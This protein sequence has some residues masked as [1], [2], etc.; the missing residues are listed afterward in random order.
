[1]KWGLN[2][3]G[4]ICQ[5][6]EQLDPFLLDGEPI[7]LVTEYKYLGFWHDHNG[8]AWTRSAR[9]FIEKASNVLGLLR[10]HCSH[11]GP[12]C[13]TELVKSYVRG[14]AEYGIALSVTWE[15]KERRKRR[16]IPAGL[17]PPEVKTAYEE[18]YKDS[19]KWIFGHHSPWMVNLR[20]AGMETPQIRLEILR[21]SV[22]RHLENTEESNPV[23]Q[24]LPSG[25]RTSR[26]MD[27]VNNCFR[28]S[29]MKRPY[30]EFCASFPVTPHWKTFCEYYVYTKML[31]KPGTLHRYVHGL[32]QKWKQDMVLTNRNVI[33]RHWAIRWR[34]GK[35]IT[36]RQQ[37]FVCSQPFNRGHINRCNLFPLPPPADYPPRVQLVLR[38][39]PESRFLS[40]QEV[41]TQRHPQAGH[42][43][44]LDWL[45]DV[46]DLDSFATLV[47]FW[48]QRS[49][50]TPNQ[51]PTSG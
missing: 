27:I 8:I 31:V 6:A 50:A 12:A 47:D 51:I 5:D 32:K 29:S 39:I 21:N 36:T 11:W 43:T 38:S 15:E 3:C 33:I 2:K 23:R 10:H 49:T 35:L 13:K 16:G 25:G 19:I 48:I 22:R 41:F 17:P 4:I 9:T 7:K 28:Y 1:M 42:F 46:G 20:L 40:Y 26:A 30:E 14:T 44:I 34:Q 18:L 45:L 24:F 37:C